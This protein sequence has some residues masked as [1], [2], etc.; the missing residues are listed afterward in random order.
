MFITRKNKYNEN[1]Y[2]KYKYK[3]TYKC[4]HC[5]K[6]TRLASINKNPIAYYLTQCGDVSAMQM[7][8]SIEEL[9]KEEYEKYNL[10]D[11]TNECYAKQI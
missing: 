9:T 6:V 3:L 8:V 7:L 1:N 11:N 5:D 2:P 10:K 4:L